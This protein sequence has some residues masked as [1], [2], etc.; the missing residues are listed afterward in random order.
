M[1]DSVAIG[2]FVEGTVKKIFPYGMLVELPGGSAGLAHIS[3]IANAFVK[4]ISAHFQ[5]GDRVTVKVLRTDERGRYQLSLRQALA[6]QG[7]EASP[8]PGPPP[9]ASPVF[10][11][12]LKRF[13]K[14]SQERL[15][16]LKRNR[17]AKLGRLRK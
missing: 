4:N 7:E 2:A 6:S 3:E 16:D 14:E 8:S 13:M 17:E 9:V 11:E 15:F 12:K 5:V 10:E 1:S